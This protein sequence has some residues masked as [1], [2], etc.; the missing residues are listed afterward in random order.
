MSGGH[1]WLAVDGCGIECFLIGYQY[2]TTIKLDITKAAAALS[3]MEK[4][5]PFMAATAIN[6]IAFRVQRAENEA[7]GDIFDNPRPFTQHATQVQK[8]TKSNLEAVVSIKP[9]QARYLDPYEDGGEHATAGGNTS[10]LVP[11]DAKTDQYGQMTKGAIAR[12]TSRADT[13]VGVGPKGIMGIWQRVKPPRV[14]R[15]GRMK[16]VQQAKP[17]LRLLV[18]FAQNQI[19]HKRL[20]FKERAERIVETEGTDVIAKALQRVLDTAFR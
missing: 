6:D 10:L 19:V 20:G 8:A 13:F 1:C 3:D 9:A 11:V 15:R 12:M 17:S 2:M 16:G 5:I 4:Q 18:R 14:G 7:I